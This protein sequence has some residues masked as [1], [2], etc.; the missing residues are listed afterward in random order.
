MT[1]NGNSDSFAVVIASRGG[2]RSKTNRYEQGLSGR[3]TLDIPSELKMRADRFE[4][5]TWLEKELPSVDLAE[6]WGDRAASTCMTLRALIAEVL[7]EIC[8]EQRQ[9]FS[10]FAGAGEPLENLNSIDT[11]SSDLSEQTSR[12]QPPS[13]SKRMVRTYRTVVPALPG[14]SSPTETDPKSLGSPPISATRLSEVLPKARL[15]DANDLAMFLDPA[16]LPSSTLPLDPTVDGF[17]LNLDFDRASEDDASCAE[18]GWSRRE[19][20]IREQTIRRPL[21]KRHV[22][23]RIVVTLTIWE[24]VSGAPVRGEMNIALSETKSTGEKIFADGFKTLDIPMSYWTAPQEE[25]FHKGLKYIFATT[26]D[27]MRDN[28]L[29]GERAKSRRDRLRTTVVAVCREVYECYAK[30]FAATV[31]AGMHSKEQSG[32]G[33]TGTARSGHQGLPL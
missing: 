29:W 11:R 25:A 20:I 1:T 5:Y 22:A 6:F 26:R 17:D 28:A 21:A 2:S 14:S 27:L 33:D 18:D 7:V 12:M 4:L 3:T 19:P 23:I 31:G 16:T 10:T 30:D 24:N 32:S 13:Q 15:E 9:R 8:A